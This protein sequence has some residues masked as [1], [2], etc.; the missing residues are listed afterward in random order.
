MVI[1]RLRDES[2]GEM[3]NDRSWEKPHP[4]GIEL[5]PITE[6]M[7]SEV[8]AEMEPEIRRRLSEKLASHYPQI[9]PPDQ[10]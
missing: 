9:K 10:G 7:L 6:E 8:R 4:S 2:V 1:E 5:P 3:M